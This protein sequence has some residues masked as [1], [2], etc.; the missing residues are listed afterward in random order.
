MYDTAIVDQRNFETITARINSMSTVI[1]AIVI[2]R[3]VAILQADNMK[4]SVII[5]RN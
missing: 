5:E 3:F 1:I 4:K 2:M